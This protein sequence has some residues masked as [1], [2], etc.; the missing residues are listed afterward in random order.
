MVFIYCLFVDILK[1]KRSYR[2]CLCVI[3]HIKKH[4]KKNIIKKYF[5]CKNQEK[6]VN[7]LQRSNKVKKELKKK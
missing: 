5:I 2:S 3:K 7:M 6:K 1:L 4:D